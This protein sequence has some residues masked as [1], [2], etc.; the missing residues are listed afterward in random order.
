MKPIGMCESIGVPTEG[1]HY[2]Q[3]A[4]LR[5]LGSSYGLTVWRL[6]RE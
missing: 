5:D 4:A 3:G 1:V 6:I 2:K